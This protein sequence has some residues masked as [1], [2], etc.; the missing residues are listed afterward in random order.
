MVGHIAERY[1]VSR[2]TIYKVA[3]RSYVELPL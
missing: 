1:K 2:T 3:P